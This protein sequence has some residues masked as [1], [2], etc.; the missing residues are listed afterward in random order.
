MKKLMLVLIL[1]LVTL[2]QSAWGQNA[3]VA[4]KQDLINQLFNE[5]GISETVEKNGVRSMKSLMPVLLNTVKDDAG[6][7]EDTKTIFVQHYF[8]NANTLINAPSFTSQLLEPLVQVYAD[9]FTVIELEKLLAF[10]RTPVGKKLASLSNELMTASIKN[11]VELATQLA[12][13]AVRLTD[14]E[15]GLK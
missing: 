2:M 14:E 15:L 7:S 13:E 11:R 6:L 9:N 4:K 8:A 1:F 12:T 3:D 10:Q 5:S